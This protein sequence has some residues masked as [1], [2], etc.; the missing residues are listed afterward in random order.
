MTEQNTS[1]CTSSALSVRSRLRTLGLSRRN[2]LSA[3]DKRL[4]SQQA[5]SHMIHYLERIVEDF[6]KTI[7]SG[8]WPIRSEIDPRPVFHFVSS[9]GGCLALPAVLDRTTMVFRKFSEGMSLE[10]MRFGTVGPGADS[11]IVSP[12]IIIVPLSVFDRQCHRLGYGGGYYD[13]AVEKLQK[14]KSSIHLFGLGFSC[15]E[16]ESIPYAEHDLVLR[17]IFTEKGFLER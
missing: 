4:F 8:Y 5:C 7:L 3:H 11:A 14:N 12:T 1:A 13:R 9:R 2:Q 6:S 15:Q 16:V 10:P 17:G